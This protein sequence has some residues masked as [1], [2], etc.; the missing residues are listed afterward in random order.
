MQKKDLDKYKD[1]YADTFKFKDENV[2]YLTKFAD[3]ICDDFNNHSFNS[4]LSLGIGFNVLSESII[5]KGLFANKIQR[6]Y[7]IDGSLEMIN[8]FKEKYKN[9][10][11]IN[12]IHSYFEDFQTDILFDRIEMGFILEHVDDPIFILT[13]FKKFLKPDG[14]IH[15][16]VPNA[17]SLHR[18][19]GHYAG[20]LDNVYTLSE[21]DKMLGHKRY[22]DLERIKQD[23]SDAGLKIEKVIGLMLKPCTGEQMN[24]LGFNKS[25]YDALVKI[26]EDYPEISNCIYLCATL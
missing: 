6:Y 22:Y 10:Q 20:L 8:Q 25:I 26:G 7:I 21:Y 15:I 2:I 14:K 5:N 18:L 16:S 19:I 13:K 11:N 4:Y 17:K 24:I 12:L 1:A 23:I 3:I 9:V